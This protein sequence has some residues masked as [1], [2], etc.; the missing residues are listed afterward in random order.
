MTINKIIH[1]LSGGAF[2]LYLTRGSAILLQSI[3]LFLIA[4]VISIEEFG[5]FT[6]LLGASQVGSVLLGLGGAQILQREMP[7]IDARQNGRGVLRLVT[8][9]L[10]Y[11]SVFTLFMLGLLAVVTSNMFNLEIFSIQNSGLLILAMGYSLGLLN[12]GISVVRVSHSATLSMLLKDTIPYLL[13]LLGF[14]ICYQQ[15]ILSAN[16]L[17]LVFSAA[18]LI[19]FAVCTVVA[20][21]YLLVR[22]GVYDKEN[23][24]IHHFIVFW[25]S[26][27]IGSLSSQVDILLAKLF[28]GETDLGIYSLLKRVTNLVSLPQIIANWSINVKVARDFALNDNDSL[29]N[30]ANEGLKISLPVAF[31]LFAGIGLFSPLWLDLFD[32]AFDAYVLITLV[33]LL[34]GQLANVLAGA[35]MLFV[36]HCRQEV[37]ALKSRV[38]SLIFG[39]IFILVGVHYLYAIGIAIGISLSILMLNIM[40]LLHVKS[41][42]GIW[43]S[44]QLPIKMRES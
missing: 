30:L 12:I 33:I 43:T 31:I 32:V 44:V 4:G 38:L 39:V 18:V 35:N 8:I 16:I 40:V 17:I 10:L 21:S 29:Q 9:A 15:N 3:T 20:M 22:T 24:K 41:K 26:S 7:V 5:Q 11:L 25:W 27:I 37:Y 6:F 2:N 13:F 28:L 23:I 34:L 1:K 19:C 42:T 14:F 36:S